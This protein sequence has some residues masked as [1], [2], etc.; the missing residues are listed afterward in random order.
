MWREVGFYLQSKDPYI[1][2]MM[3]ISFLSLIVIF[4]RLIILQFVFYLDFKK[5]AKNLK[6]MLGA[7]DY[8]RAMN[9]CKHTSHTSLPLIA[10]RALEAAETDPTKIRGTIEEETIDFLP[11]IETRL[12]ILPAFAIAVLLVGVLGTIDSLWNTFHS[13]EILDTVKKQAVIGQNVASALS[14]TALGLSICLVILVSY[15]FLK[16]IALRLTERLQYGVAVLHN[17]LVPQEIGSYMPIVE[18]GPQMESMTSAPEVSA[19]A[20]TAAA[21]AP[22]KEE[23]AS[24]D[25]FN[26]ASV[27]DIKDEEEI[28]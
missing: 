9:Y 4:E 26:D 23:V 14:H 5:F 16:G 3:L 1:I 22:K 28:I 7:D 2:A 15:Q 17:L 19:P 25:A 18:H 24:D 10:L 8:S 13:I 12:S 21:A 11:K 20:P 6:K 27:E